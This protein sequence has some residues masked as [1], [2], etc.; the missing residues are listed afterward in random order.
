MPQNGVK[1][2]GWIA[3]FVGAVVLVLALITAIGNVSVAVNSF[4]APS[5]F[6]WQAEVGIELVV[7]LAFLIPGIALVGRKAK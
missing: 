6:P 3:I 4:D 7:A 1:E 2:A 5:G